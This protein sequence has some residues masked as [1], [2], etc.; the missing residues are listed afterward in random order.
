MY[1]L[2]E[3]QVT[4]STISK[5]SLMNIYDRIDFSKGIDVSKTSASKQCDI[6]HYWYFLDKGFNFQPYIR[7]GCHD[8]SIMSIK[9]DNIAILN[10]W[11]VDYCCNIYGIS[12]SD[13]VNL[14]QNA[15]LTEKTGILLKIITYKI[16]KESIRFG[17]NEI[18]KK[19]SLL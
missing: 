15:N 11:G 14:L 2:A 13:A 16:G 9:T 6:S 10:I 7:S 19:I 17:D 18:E 1:P 5:L 12:K 3:K 4:T 8:L